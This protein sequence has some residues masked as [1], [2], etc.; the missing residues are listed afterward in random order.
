MWRWQ[1]TNYIVFVFV[2][3]VVLLVGAVWLLCVE[4]AGYT[5][6]CFVFVVLVVLLVGA[7]WLLSVEVAGYTLY[8]FCA[9][10]ASCFVCWCCMASQ[11]VDGR[12]QT[13]LFLYLFC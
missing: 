2:V 4:V 13:T 11:G 7:V 6:Y 3:L 5:L 10:C 1:G 9:C 8:C 12:V